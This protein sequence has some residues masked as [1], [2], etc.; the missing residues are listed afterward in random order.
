[1][2]TRLLLQR[3]DKIG[4]SLEKKEGALALLALGSC[5]LEQERLD[6]F[7]DLDFFVIVKTGYKQAFLNNLDWLE[8]IKTVSFKFKNTE[9]GFKALYADDVF[10][11][12]AVFDEQEFKGLKLL[13][14]RTVWKRENYNIE[15]QDKI[16]ENKQEAKASSGKI[17]WMTGEALTNL[18]VGLGRFL[19][20]EKLSAFNFV[21]VYAA[22]RIVDL[23][24][25]NTKPQNK[26]QDI[27]DSSR[28]FEQLYPDYTGINKFLQ[29]Y[30]KTP[31]SAEEIIKFLEANYEVNSFIG[32]K[33]HNLIRFCK[34]TSL[35]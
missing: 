15:S 7:S 31:E 2:K 35:R 4:N 16:G 28:R 34:N 25:A 12:F 24:K 10:C 27:Y 20:G 9:D 29:G 26:F 32:E 21:Q 33:I 5:G 6:E 19:R 11:E 8:N 23:I 22:G 17:Q 1:M 3:L 13:N 30:D 18:Y 14:F